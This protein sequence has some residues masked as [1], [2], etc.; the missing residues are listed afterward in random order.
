MHGSVV[1]QY[2]GLIRIDTGFGTIGI[3]GVFGY[4]PNNSMNGAESMYGVTHGWALHG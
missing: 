1:A 3:V 4:L 2:L